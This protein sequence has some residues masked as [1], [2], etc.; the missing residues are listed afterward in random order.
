M[1]PQNHANNIH[2]ETSTTA[3]LSISHQHFFAHQKHMGTPVK[4]SRLLLC[5]GDFP[6]PARKSGYSIRYYPI[7]QH[8]SSH[9]DIDIFAT[10]YWAVA[11]E[12]LQAAR[13]FCKNVAIYRHQK[14]AP[15]L[16][17]KVLT[18]IKSFIPGSIPFDF[19]NYDQLQMD[20]FFAK[21][22]SKEHYDLV[23][24]ASITLVNTVKKHANFDRLTLDVIDSPYALKLRGANNL[25]MKIDALL[26]RYWE[27]K[28]IAAVD[29]ASYISPLDRQLG[30]G[31]NPPS[32]VSVIPNGV[33]LDDSIN[34][35]KSFGSLSIGFLGN[36]AY[37]PN[38]QAAKKLY[39]LFKQLQTSFPELKLIIIGRDP[40]N[41]ITDLAADP[42]VVITGTVDNIWP[43]IYGVD[44]FVFP[45]MTGSGQQN[46]LLEAM[47]ARKPI[48]STSLGNSG[49]GAIDG[50]D[51]IIAD[52][53]NSI[54]EKIQNLLES[55]ESRKK[56]GDLAYDFVMSKYAWSSVFN[57]LKCTLFFD[58]NDTS[59]I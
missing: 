21:S 47:A 14:T 40:V 53:D 4:K 50:T 44:L 37:T 15:S 32:H 10:I 3:R 42:N 54:M 6:F 9:F 49:V 8:F 46:K 18:R 36:M 43:Y 12:D 35:S 41:E 55:P 16:F 19:I 13:G 48:I 31:H 56:L 30:C 33:Y 24:C 2:S 34:A 57:K 22:Y 1:T 26:I 38:I 20:D 23:V 39:I 59:K 52:T 11:D 51:I 58:K 17:K 45:M 29:H 25:I 5:L 27:Q 28:T 7:I